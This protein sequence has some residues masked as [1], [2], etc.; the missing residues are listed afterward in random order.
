MN[1]IVSSV[2]AALA[3]T[4]AP[5][6]AADMP[7]K[8]KVAAPA[9]APSPFDIGI[10]GVVMSDYIF[11]GVSQSNKGASG[12]AY[13]EPQ[14]NTSI[15]TFYV[16]L[17][18]YAISWPSGAGYGF[19]DPSAEIDIYG[20]WRNSWGPVSLDLGTIYYFYPSE[21]NNGFTTNSDFVEIYGKGGLD[22]GHGLSVG[23]NVFYT[24]D[25]LH[26]S[27]TFATL[28]ISDKP[29]ALYVSGTAKWVTPWAYNGI[30]SYLSGELGHWW[31]EDSGFLAA[32]ATADPSYTYWNVGIA[33]TYKALT[34]DLRYHDTDQSAQ[35]CA[36]FLLVGVPNNSNGWCDA[37]FVASLKFDTSLSALK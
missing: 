12:G 8:S 33:F 17:A 11:R 15:G 16:G 6:F 9:A 31:I 10:G 1:K 18:G 23:A 34:L 2:V 5:A 3:V 25:L 20:G 4:A 37:R 21:S 28:G 14:L 36:N 24:P 30:G 26:Y 19:T 13:F 27:E 7:V 32:G 35:D 22:L 29:D